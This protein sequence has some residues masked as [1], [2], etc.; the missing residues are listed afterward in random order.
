M[1][2]TS[3]GGPPQF[4]IHDDGDSVAVAVVDL[5]P[6]SVHGAVLKTG[7]RQSFTLKE[8]VPLGH[9]F[10]VTDLAEGSD[11]IKYGVR[12]AV[13]TKAISVGDYVHVHNIRSARWLSSR[14]S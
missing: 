2:S 1:S 6:G 12:V 13:V 3:A 10:A 8:R 4:L 14:A 7:Q 5:E 11:L 9:K